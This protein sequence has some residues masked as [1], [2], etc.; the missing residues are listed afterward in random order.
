MKCFQWISLL[1][2]CTLFLGACSGNDNEPTPTPTALVLSTPSYSNLSSNKVSLSSDVSGNEGASITKSGFCYATR[3]GADIHDQEVAA[4]IVSQKISAELT[5]LSP[6]TTYYVKAFASVYN[7][8]PVYSS[9]TSFTTSE[10]TSEDILANYK[11]PTYKD[12]YTDIAGWDQRDQWNLSNVHDPTVMKADD[13]YFYMYQT[14]VSYGNVHDGHGHFHARRSQDLVNW[15]YMGASMPA[16]PSWA[17]EKLNEIRT[18]Q[19]LM[20]IESPVFYHWAPVVR[21]VA[22]GK[23]RM[24]YSIVTNHFIGSGKPGHED[25]FDNTWSERAFIGMMETTDPASNVWEDKG[26]V[27]CSSTDKGSDWYRSSLNDWNGYFKWNAIDPTYTITPG[28]EHWLTYGSWHSGI[29][30]LQVDPETGKPLQ[31]LGAP[32]RIDDLPN[33]GQLVYTRTSGSRWQGSEG[34]EIIYNPETGFYYLF[35]A[36]DELSVAYNTRVCRSPNI[37]GPY[38]GIDGSSIT[39]GGEIYPIATY[40]YKFKNDNG[41]VGISHCAVF[42]DGEGNWYYASQGRLPHNVPGIHDSNA[43]M[44]GHVRSIRWTSTGWPVVMPE[45]Y[46]AVPQ[47]NIEESELI[48]N[49]EH[50]NLFHEYQKQHVSSSMTLGADHKVTTGTWKG[51]TWSYNPESQTLTINGIELCLQRETDWEAVPRTHTI[52]YAGYGGKQ[53]HWGKKVQ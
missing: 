22:P 4:T 18:E 51:S 3:P 42:D 21:K 19:G 34:P 1:L 39:N 11:A 53:T 25:F 9:E 15:E 12:N 44:M 13:G 7:E 2:S 46:G 33:Y 37:T 49:W 36:Y 28:G 14:D 5:G 27:I 8:S 26:Y 35:M 48:G 47:V 20:P 31:E 52:V 45:R 32:W 50:I 40:P 23:Y 43:V 30:T 29:A 24:Y 6:N 41:W 17:K 38:V 16:T 10:K